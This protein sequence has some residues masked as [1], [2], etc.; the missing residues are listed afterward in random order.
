MGPPFF[1]YLKYFS[2]WMLL[3]GLSHAAVSS[4]REGSV[5]TTLIP[6]CRPL[7]PAPI[8]YYYST[9]EETGSCTAVHEDLTARMLTESEVR[10]CEALA[11]R[12]MGTLAL[13]HG[14]F[15]VPVTTDA[16]STRNTSPPRHHEEPTNFPVD[17]DQLPEYE[18][19]LRG[20][21]VHPM[22]FF[23][24]WQ[25]QLDITVSTT[26]EDGAAKEAFLAKQQAAGKKGM[27]TPPPPAS[28]EAAKF[29][30]FFPEEA[31]RQ[32]YHCEI[33]N[34]VVAGGSQMD[35]GLVDPNLLSFA[36][37]RGAR[38]GDEGP[39]DEEP[40]APSPIVLSGVSQLGHRSSSAPIWTA[41][42]AQSLTLIHGSLHSTQHI[43]V[44][45]NAKGQRP[46]CLLL[47]WK[48]AGIG[49]AEVDILDV[50]CSCLTEQ[51]RGDA[52]VL[53][54]LLNEYSGWL[55][56]IY[57]AKRSVLSLMLSCRDV[58]RLRSYSKTRSEGFVW[59]AVHKRAMI[60]IAN[61]LE[62]A[63]CAEASS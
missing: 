59:G 2:P 33:P 35:S 14:R 58:A 39:D 47:D 5:L 26:V 21:L 12:V 23:S 4:M 19:I 29:G 48:H 25:S 6:H 17:R 28:A 42:K 34:L 11:S 18:R 31:L 15:M 16:A 50:M 43:A 24:Q 53:R 8:T 10:P 44:S 27:Y 9:H 62:L 49:P 3:R 63:I 55:S 36:S 37:Q 46:S 56:D 54:R 13:L 60:A 52:T 40:P 22:I 45:R 7:S 20:T 57:G 32:L 38:S 30:V 1:V 41:T 61:T 51:E